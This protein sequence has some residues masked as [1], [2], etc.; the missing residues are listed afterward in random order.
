MRH[1][2]MTMVEVMVAMAIT[3]VILMATNRVM[4]SSQRAIRVAAI[5]ADLSQQAMSVC[6]RIADDLKDAIKTSVV[7]ANTISVNGDSVTTDISFKKCVGYE[8]VGGVLTQVQS[9]QISY[10]LVTEVRQGKTVWIIR[11]TEAAPGG[12][13]I[14]DLTDSA[15]AIGLHFFQSPATVYSVSV[16]LIREV[17]TDAINDATSTAV[18]AQDAATSG[19]VSDLWKYNQ[20]NLNYF[21]LQ[22][23]TMV[24]VNF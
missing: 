3:S 10:Q 18:T 16:Q 23:T 7:T 21:L 17:L 2:G 6:D 15:T 24:H 14:V 20:N 12:N 4:M 8:K 11:R 19:Y 22:R 5:E 13:Q 9:N 1:R